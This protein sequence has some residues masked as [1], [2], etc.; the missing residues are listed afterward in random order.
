[1]RFLEFKTSVE[2]MPADLTAIMGVGVPCSIKIEW[3]NSPTLIVRIFE[4]I[5]TQNRL[6]LIERV[7]TNR[8]V[9]EGETCE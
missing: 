3:D 2:N 9:M 7:L 1:M 4:N 8:L 6:K 5:D